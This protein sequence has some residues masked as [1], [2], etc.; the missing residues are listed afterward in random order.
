MT[1]NFSAKPGIALNSIYLTCIILFASGI[2]YNHIQLISHEYP[3]DYNEGGMLVITSTLEQGESP[4]SLQS[5]PARISVY[6]I[7]YNSLVAQFSRAFGATLEL[8]R[9]VAAIF[10]FAC[11]A[12]CFYLC[13]KESVAITESFTAAALLY[14][15]L[16]HYSTPIASPNSL[17]LFLFLSAITIPWVYGFS[18]RS[19]GTAIVLGILAF[20]TKQYFIACLGYVALYLFIA[21]SKKRA[22]FF[23]LTA[24]ATFIVVMIFVFYISPYYFDDT[25]FAVQSAAKFTSSYEHL[26]T[27]LKEYALIYLPLLIVLVAWL[28]KKCCS[29][30]FLSTQHG[31]NLPRKN[32]VNFFDIDAPLLLLKPNYIWMCCACSM[33]IISLSLGKSLGNYLTYFFQL[34]SPFLLVGIFAL[35]SDMPKWRWPIKILIV[36][37]LYNNY[38]MLPTDF[39]VEENNWQIIRQEIAEADDLYASTLV[40]QE[41]L[42][43]NAPI[44]LN[45]HTR[46]FPFGEDKPARFMK[47]DEE[48]RVSVIWE[49]HIELIQTKIKTQAFDVLL[50]DQYMVFPS[51]SQN[52]AADTKALLEANYKRTADLILPLASRRGAG[53]FNVQIWKPILA[54]S[55]ESKQ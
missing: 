40:L 10:I 27:Q 1:A 30:L 4:Y 16:L 11:C 23:G 34:I 28:V 3:L 26:I 15:G 37:A 17:G 48:K 47:S 18:K 9:A 25:F 14:A 8:H 42:E 7:L 20:Y 35:I 50:I 33:F 54:T 19:L 49:R 46:Y 53:S 21:E 45:G 24:L 51:S 36:F 31:E 13:R 5:Q 29:R 22:V 6:P 44:Y 52:S 39:S 12:T 41:T 38:T 2:T 32:L 55:D 43:K